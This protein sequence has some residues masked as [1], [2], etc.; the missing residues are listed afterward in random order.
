MR[1]LK[2]G[3]GCVRGWTEADMDRVL[4]KLEEARFAPGGVAVEM[5]RGEVAALAVL[6]EIKAAEAVQSAAFESVVSG[7][8]REQGMGAWL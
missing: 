6:T 3:G 8:E 5:T 4:R 7:L 1:A 2:V